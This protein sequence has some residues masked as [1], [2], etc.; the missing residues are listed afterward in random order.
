MIGLRRALF[1]RALLTCALLLAADAVRAS[2]GEASQPTPFSRMQPEG[3]VAGWQPLRPARNAAPTHYRLID[4]GSM[5]VLKAEA[6]R[7]MSGLIHPVE[8]DV[9]RYPK[10]RWRWKVGGPVAN[11]DMTQK[12][13][14]D[15][16]ARIYV[17]FDYP[18]ERLSFGTRAKLKLAESL[19]GQKIPAAAINYVWDSRQPVGTILPNAYTDRARMIVVQSGTERSGQWVTETRDLAADFRSAFGEDPPNVIAVAIATDT[20]NTGEK[21]TAWYGDIEFL[22]AD[23]GGRRPATQP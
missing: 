15:Y 19:Y 13:G 23:G 14:D 2:A 20:D 3:T 8:V 11:A 10:L 1:T 17:M 18:L 9:R 7:S 12:S 21:A 6:E 5:V 22:P 4:D 16:A